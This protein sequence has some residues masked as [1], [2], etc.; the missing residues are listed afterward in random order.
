VTGAGTRFHH[1]VASGDPRT[2]RVVIWTRVTTD[3]A[4][5]ADTQ[6]VMARD[7]EL[8][9]VVAAGIATAA[10]EH[11]HTVSVDVTGLEPDTT[12]FY[13]FESA[14]E[15]SPVARTRTL[16]ER[17]D[18]LRFAMVSCAKFNAGFFN[19]YA[20]IAERDDLQFL[21]HLGDYIYEASN[22]PPPTQTPGADI[23]RPWPE[24]R[25][26]LG[27][28]AGHPCHQETG[29]GAAASQFFE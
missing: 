25:C 29:V 10:A 8:G 9:D 20:R 23:G 16:P 19:A 11:D 2:D 27:A 24:G 12:Y 3:A 13:G 4:Q 1:G 26:A 15:R 14:G 21:L 28:A 5:P 18:H 6:W 22:I 17:T 7:R